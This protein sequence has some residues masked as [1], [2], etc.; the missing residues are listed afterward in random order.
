MEWRRPGKRAT[1][2]EKGKSGK[3]EGK[4]ERRKGGRKGR[5]RESVSLLAGRTSSGCLVLARKKGCDEG[6]LPL[7]VVVPPY[8]RQLLKMRA[9]DKEGTE[10]EREKGR[11]NGVQ[12]DASGPSGKR[13]RGKRSIMS[14]SSN[15]SF[16]RSISPCPSFLPSIPS[17]VTSLLLE[18]ASAP[19]FLSHIVPHDSLLALIPSLS[20]Q[21]PTSTPSLPP[22]CPPSL[23]S[24][25]RLT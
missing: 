8:V 25:L 14:P 7:E 4:G 3:T 11:K 12:G 2:E 10:G 16:P 9:R 20:S 1:K 5:E 6:E 13:T 19:T 15:P 17:Q 21:S 18:I 24:T 23:P 22:S